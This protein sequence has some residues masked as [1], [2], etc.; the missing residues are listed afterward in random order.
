MPSIGN[1]DANIRVENGNVSITAEEIYHSSVQNQKENDYGYGDENAGVEIFSSPGETRS[2][3]AV[4]VDNWIEI[5]G[6]VIVHNSGT[7]QPSDYEGIGD[8]NAGVHIHRESGETREGQTINETD[9]V[10]IFGDNVN[11]KESVVS[12]ETRQV[13]GVLG[14]IYVL[15]QYIGPD[16]I[17][18]GQASLKIKNIDKDNIIHEDDIIT[19]FQPNASRLYMVSETAPEGKTLGQDSIDVS[20]DINGTDPNGHFR[21]SYGN[22]LESDH[23]HDPEAGIIEQFDEVQYPSNCDIL[24]NGNSLGTALGDGNGTFVENIDLTQQ[25]ELGQVNTIE[26]T[27]DTLGHIMAYVEGDVSR[28]VSGRG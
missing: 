21:L 11:Y 10:E 14:T 23:V 2:G 8:E 20:L 7:G 13:N 5:Y 3:D 25:L 22:T 28:D 27:S 4:D 12:E 15:V 6:D 26:I 18:T 16:G 1:N 24:I 9:W 19:T 17:N